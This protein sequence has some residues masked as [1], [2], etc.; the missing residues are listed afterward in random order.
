MCVC[1]DEGMEEYTGVTNSQAAT[2][3]ET[4]K[5]IT[6]PEGTYDAGRIADLGSAQELANLE[7]PV[8]MAQQRLEREADTGLTD[9]EKEYIEIMDNKLK[10]NKK[11]EAINTH[12]FKEV[13]DDKGRKY[14]V[15]HMTPHETTVDTRE[16]YKPG[17]LVLMGKNG[18]IGI[19]TTLSGW[20]LDNK[21]TEEDVIRKLDLVDLGDKLERPVENQLP[22]LGD[23][24]RMDVVLRDGQD[25]KEAN[26]YAY[27]YDLSNPEGFTD[28]KN[29]V[30]ISELRGKNL[31]KSSSFVKAADMSFG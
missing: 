16:Y 8:A 29:A 4:N 21:S 15:L 5:T 6:A 23:G 13:V 30:A 7:K 12:A 18:P 1:E 14:L 28:F 2:Y 9:Q 20:G 17:F 22:A 31:A 26:V 25:K 19:S 3:A 10:F 27:R 11:G 24:G